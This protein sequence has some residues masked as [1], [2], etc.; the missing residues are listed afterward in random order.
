[1]LEL[2]LIHEEKSIDVKRS[3]NI[4]YTHVTLYAHISQINCFRLESEHKLNKQIMTDL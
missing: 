4:M 1:M 3:K 2:K